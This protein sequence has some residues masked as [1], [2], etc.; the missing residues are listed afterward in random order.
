MKRKMIIP[1]TIIVRS[2]FFK[3]DITQI[4]FPNLPNNA[5]QRIVAN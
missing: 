2:L 4:L 5:L 1:R 3:P